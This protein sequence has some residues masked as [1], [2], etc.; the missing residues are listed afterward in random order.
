VEA[1]H[2]L[3]VSERQKLWKAFGRMKCKEGWRIINSEELQKVIRG[4]YIVKFINEQRIKWR[5]HLKRMEDVKLAKKIT[6]WNPTGLRA[7]GRPK[8]RWR[9]E[10]INYLKKLKLRNFSQHFT[11]RKA[12]NDL[13]QRTKTMWGWGVRIIIRRRIKRKKKQKKKKKKKKKKIA[14]SALP[15]A[16]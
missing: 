14:V 8:D 13:E 16:Y 2:D 4:D 10:V 7:K 1:E 9:D 12:W 5:G 11:S 3:L 15:V 6:D